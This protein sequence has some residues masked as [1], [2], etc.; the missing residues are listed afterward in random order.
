MT[1]WQPAYDALADEARR[2]YVGEDATVATTL[3]LLSNWV[4]IF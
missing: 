1:G 2:R 3:K 4:Q